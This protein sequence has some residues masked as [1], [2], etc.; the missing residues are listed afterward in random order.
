MLA[1]VPLDSGMIL[2]LC[3]HCLQFSS[4]RHTPPERLREVPGAKRIGPYLVQSI[5]D[6]TLRILPAALLSIVALRALL[7]VQCTASPVPLRCRVDRA[8]L[9]FGPP[10]RC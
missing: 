8:E 9:L 3:R 1:R 10:G 5:G 4:E 2:D 7:Y 6:G